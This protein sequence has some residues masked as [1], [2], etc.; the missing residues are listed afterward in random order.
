MKRWLFPISLALCLA[1]CSSVADREP[2][3]AQAYAGPVSLQVR[4]EL[5]A[6]AALVATLKHGDR[7]DI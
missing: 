7:I 4:D 1:G 3:L 6:R 5:V 2:T